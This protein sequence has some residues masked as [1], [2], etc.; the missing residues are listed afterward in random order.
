ML[1]HCGP[2]CRGMGQFGRQYKLWGFPLFQR[3]GPGGTITDT[4]AEAVAI[5]L[6]NEFCFAI[7]NGQ[8]ALRA[9][10]DTLTAPRA[11]V[12]INL[13]NVSLWHL[14]SFRADCFRFVSTQILQR[15]KN[16]FLDLSQDNKNNYP[17]DNRGLTRNPM[18]HIFWRTHPSEKHFTVL[19]VLY[20]FYVLFFENRFRI[21]KTA[22]RLMELNESPKTSAP[23]RP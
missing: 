14:F 6:F 16:F 18:L 10:H 22:S 19:W 12:F 1:M 11:L 7:N 13:D 5:T 17:G 9:V 21:P 23:R 15:K 20:V 4:G 8:G 3:Q 2:R